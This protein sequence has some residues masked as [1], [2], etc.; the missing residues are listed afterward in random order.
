MS[1]IIARSMMCD[2]RLRGSSFRVRNTQ[3]PLIH[4]RLSF[5]DH[6]TTVAASTRAVSAAAA[7]AEAHEAGTVNAGDMG[8]GGSGISRRPRSDDGPGEGGRRLGE[9]DLRPQDDDE[10]DDVRFIA[11]KT[12]SEG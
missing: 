2:S 3:D 9:G 8:R 1:N 12:N 10:D 4:G 11:R 7:T 6:R 5:H